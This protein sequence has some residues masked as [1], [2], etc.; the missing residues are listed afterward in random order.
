[1][2]ITTTTLGDNSVQVT[3][4]GLTNTFSGLYAAIKSAITASGV[5]SVHD[6]F[7][8]T[9]SLLGIGTSF[10]AGS[11]IIGETYVIQSAGTTNFTLIGAENNT[12]GTLFVATGIGTGTG[13]ARFTEAQHGTVQTLVLKSLNLDAITYKYAIFRFNI[14]EG[15]IDT[16]TCESWNTTTHVATN[17]AWTFHD[18]ASVGFKLD[19]TDIL[20]FIHP[21][22]IYVHSYIAGEPTKWSGVVELSRDD[23]MDTP[24]A[25][26]PCWGWL[27]STLWGIGSSWG[28]TP[29]AT[30]QE[31]TLICLPRAADG[32]VGINAAKSFASDYGIS[33]YPNWLNTGT[34]MP[35]INHVLGSVGGKF[36]TNGWDTSKR[37]MHPIKPIFKYASATPTPYGLAQGLKVLAPAGNNMGKIK[38]LVDSNGN[39]SAQGVLKEH[40]LLNTH[41]KSKNLDLSSTSWFS[42]QWSKIDIFFATGETATGVAMVGGSYYVTTSN[43]R[44]IQVTLAGGIVQVYPT[45]KTLR[46][47]KFDGEKYVYVGTTDGLIRID[48]TNNSTLFKTVSNG[49]S[50]ICITGEY[51]V[52]SW[53]NDSITP[54]VHRLLRRADFATTADLPTGTVATFTQSRNLYGDADGNGICYF[55]DQNKSTV[56]ETGTVSVYRVSLAGA[57]ANTTPFTAPSNNQRSTVSIKVID[58]K[59]LFAESCNGY[60]SPYTS[61]AWLINYQTMAQAAS[62][63]RTSAATSGGVAYTF[64]ENALLKINGLLYQIANN[65]GASTHEACIFNPCV[66]SEISFTQSASI[67]D[68]ALG[69]GSLTYITAETD[70][71]RI[72]TTVANGMRIWSGFNGEMQDGTST[73]GQVALLV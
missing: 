54:T 48:I 60:T 58:N 17:E 65:D 61:N 41:H 8:G 9:G 56:T 53:G 15:Y 73:L 59:Y 4:E 72:I 6:E 16:S 27:S 37:E 11:F 52:A 32:S 42:Q 49:C 10:T 21:R 28:S 18:C 7:L 22:Y 29:L 66:T 64:A 69:L 34:S 51:I 26:L 50:S 12:V 44:V 20:L 67:I 55:I 36:A 3:A 57:I 45:G 35:P 25:G 39:Y 43:N 24:Q 19:K 13:T 33:S 40:W 23:V 46:G 14:V 71:A 63:T 2:P 30:S 5:W 1:M 62:L 38:A 47:I 31:H 70:G 68:S